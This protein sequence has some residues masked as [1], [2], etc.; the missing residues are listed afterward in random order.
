MTT[1]KLGCYVFPKT[2][3]LLTLF[4]VLSLSPAA[5]HAALGDCSQP[6]SSG[7]AP[8][9]TDCLYI[10]NAS[11]G[12]QTCDPA[13]ICA[14]TGTLPAKATDA[15]LCLNASVGVP[16]AL[17]C[18]CE[19][20]STESDDFNDNSKDTSKWGA[21]MTDG[22]GKLTETNQRLEYTCNSGTAQDEMD[23]PWIAS[24]LPFDRNWE[25]QIDL[26]NSTSPSTSDQE[27][28][29]GI[30]IVNAQD[31]GD[32]LYAEMIAS[33]FGTGYYS[34]LG[35]DGEWIAEL[36]TFGVA[37]ASGAVRVRFASSTKVV[38]V[39]Y[40]TNPSD[41]YQWTELVTFG[42]GGSGGGFAWT[43][44]GLSDTDVM[45]AYVYGYSVGMKVTAGTM[46]AD[47]FLL[48]GGVPAP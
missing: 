26:A 1:H 46:W 23:W 38:E 3:V 40:D 37:I 44:W 45:Y 2:G 39:T 36:G 31:F 48:T 17:N 34:E 19:P 13:C 27:N 30:G 28:S 21:A 35:T 25:M 29:F 43:D 5:G 6:A 9:A 11:V 8:V 22:N 41:G 12:L 15:L 16:V 24:A 10:L 32:Y 33:S 14:P 42:L 18:P 7:S 47:N 20:V 4:V